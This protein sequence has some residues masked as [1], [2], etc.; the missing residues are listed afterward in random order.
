MRSAI[1]VCS[2]H[3]FVFLSSNYLKWKQTKACT[4]YVNELR[5]VA[6]AHMAMCSVCVCMSAFHLVSQFKVCDYTMKYVLLSLFLFF[7]L[8]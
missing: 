4:S 6:A 8:F 7:V 3:S 2:F 1:S 5:W